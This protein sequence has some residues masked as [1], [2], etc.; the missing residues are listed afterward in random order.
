MVGTSQAETRNTRPGSTGKQQ[1]GGVGR[2]RA[3]P[4]AWRAETLGAAEENL[5]GSVSAR[6]SGCFSVQCSQNLPVRQPCFLRNCPIL[7]RG[8]GHT[9]VHLWPGWGSR[10]ISVLQGAVVPRGEWLDPAICFKNLPSKII[11]AKV[12][13]VKIWSV[14]GLWPLVRHKP[15]DTEVTM[16]TP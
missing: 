13:G 3:G 2:G 16:L 12:Y 14:A 6:L 8:H 10:A 1:E 11:I 4:A 15:L 9:G 7:L 5:L